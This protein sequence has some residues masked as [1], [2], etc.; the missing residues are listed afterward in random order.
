MDF[1]FERNFN[2]SFCQI[3]NL[4]LYLNGK[5]ALEKLLGKS[6]GKRYNAWYMLFGIC[7]SMSRTPTCVRG[8]VHDR[9][10]SIEKEFFSLNYLPG[11]MYFS[12]PVPV[13]HWNLKYLKTSLFLSLLSVILDFSLQKTYPYQISR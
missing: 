3:S 11:H 12:A 10:I 5:K 8:H 7:P 9:L 2:I 6:L 13:F 4:S 1:F